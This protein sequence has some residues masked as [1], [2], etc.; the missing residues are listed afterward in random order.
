MLKKSDFRKATRKGIQKIEELSK[1]LSSLDCPTIARIS[2]IDLSELN[3]AN[4]I[5]KKL[6]NVPTGRAKDDDELDFIYV[7]QIEPTGE[8]ILESLKEL[9][10]LE[11]YKKTGH[12]YPQINDTDGAGISLYVGRSK[13]LRAR[14]KQ[15]LG[16]GSRKVYALHLECW[17][18]SMEGN[19]TISYLEFTNQNNLLI[20]AIEDSIWDELKPAFGRR[21]SK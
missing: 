21:G 15:H 14:L 17:A 12:A 3:K 9:L 19:I 4:Y 13:N 11:K 8:K 18:A 6:A 20:Q 16:G 5:D 1:S 7:V 2:G 10:D